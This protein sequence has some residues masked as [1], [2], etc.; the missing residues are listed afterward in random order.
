MFETLSRELDACREYKL[1]SRSVTMYFCCMRSFLT[2]LEKKSTLMNFTVSSQTFDS[3][4]LYR[5]QFV[6]DACTMERNHILVRTWCIG[7]PSERN[8]PPR[9]L[10]K[11]RYHYSSFTAKT[12]WK[13]C[14]MSQYLCARLYGQNAIHQYTEIM[15]VKITLLVTRVLT[16]FRNKF[17]FLA[18]HALQ[19]NKMNFES[20]YLTF[21]TLFT[22]KGLRR[23]TFV[24]NVFIVSSSV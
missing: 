14:L 20:F 17:T 22:H 12:K 7:G 5:S 19:N 18:Y 9:T 10:S 8:L 24:S 13:K 4:F 1:Q 3:M 16:S 23:G 21:N 2:N 15:H 6:V 11:V